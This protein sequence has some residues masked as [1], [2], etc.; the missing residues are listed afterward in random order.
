M[1][2]LSVFLIAILAA[3]LICVP[4]SA[5]QADPAADGPAFSDL[6]G[7]WGSGYI[8]EA[9]SR[10][11]FNGY[12]DGRFGPDDIITRAQFITVLWRYAGK[13]EPEVP[14]PFE[15]IAGQS[16]EFRNAIAWGYEN[17]YING[18]GDNRFDPAG[19]LT[20]EA[21]V[22]IL[23]RFAGGNSGME[24]LFASSYDAY[25]TDSSSVSAWAKP[26]MYWAYYNEIVQG[27]GEAELSPASVTTRAQ[28]SAV[29][30]KYIDRTGN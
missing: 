27:T 12:P 16:E 2:P 8:T 21:A 18:V 1:R 11:Y 7:H 30:V 24:M 6:D 13:P 14:A 15:D 10:G 28:L 23:F 5:G 9:V 22:S 29:L 3:S 4:V 17:S 20:R 19:G 26:A 25:F